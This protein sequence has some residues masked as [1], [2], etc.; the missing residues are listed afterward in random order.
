MSYPALTAAPEDSLPIEVRVGESEQQRRWTVLVRLLLV[1][2]H[3]VALI[4]LQ[5][6]GL[7]VVVA[8]WW[9]AL[10][11]GRVP[12]SWWEFLGGVLR[13]STRVTGYGIFLT[14]RYPPFSLAADDGYPIDV[15]FRSGRF[16]RA[17]VL[18]R[19]PLVAPAF[20][21]NSLAFF[22]LYV[23]ALLMW[24]VTLLVGRLPQPCFEAE[25]AILR[26][27]MRTNGYLYFLTS[28]YPAKL[29]G[30]P[31]VVGEEALERRPPAEVLPFTAQGAPLDSPSTTATAA[32][33]RLPKVHVP[34]PPPRPPATSNW[35]LVLSPLA[36][37]VLVV[38]MVVGASGWLL[39]GLVTRAVGQSLSTATVALR[40]QNQALDA[41]DLLG[42]QASAFDRTETGCTS[43][44]CYQNAYTTFATNISR[45]VQ[46]LEG[47]T[48]PANAVEEAT[49]AE[50]AGVNAATIIAPLG[51][52][53]GGSTTSQFREAVRSV[54]D[55]F[56][57]LSRRL[58]SD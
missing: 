38:V 55:S 46:T 4:F 24:L 16:N 43:T 25:A 17:A 48:Y 15:A 2:P 49:M 29:F 37:G 8:S 28:T 54:D 13:W 41:Y 51:A 31:Q 53:P 36:R 23:F 6:A 34:T 58:A 32:T 52:R 3:V 35:R 5:L 47:I 9:A 39:A 22:G 45:Y 11:T 56:S 7:F 33:V 1:L 40:A 19:P 44:S 27:Q 42:N 21:V 20:V 57:R 10:I 30:D 26:F 12:T 50:H 14:D 18:F